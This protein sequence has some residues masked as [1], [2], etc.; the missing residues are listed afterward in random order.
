MSINTYAELQT[1]VAAWIHRDDLT[2]HIPDFIQQGEALLNRKL[3]T[4][5]M[6]NVT[7]LTASTLS[8]N[9]SLP[10]GFI[11][12]QSLWIE[13]TR[14]EIQYIVPSLMASAISTASGRPEYF[15]IT[16]SIEFERVPDAAYSIECRYFKRYNLA[17]D[18]TNTLLTNNPEIYLHAALS[19]A[20]LFIVDD[21][22]LSMFKQLLESEINE[23]NLSEDRKRGSSLAVLRTELDLE[24]VFDIVNG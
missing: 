24:P 19:C 20:A 11:E 16:S 18:Q 2:A 17:N 3:R 5:D 12:M 15:T 14:D 7:T 6:E 21:A 4:V 1:A 10:S 8:R 9:V 13:S 22:R 23:L